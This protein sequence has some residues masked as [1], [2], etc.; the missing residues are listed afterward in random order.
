MVSPF[1]YTCLVTEV[2]H[3]DKLLGHLYINR[4]Y[5]SHLVDANCTNINCNR[6]QKSIEAKNVAF[7]N[8]I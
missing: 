7:E 3:V 2:S 4:F 8:Y 6:Y 5:R 1:L